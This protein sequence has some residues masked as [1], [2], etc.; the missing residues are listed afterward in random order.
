MK[1]REECVVCIVKGLCRSKKTNLLF[2]ADCRPLVH[3]FSCRCLQMWSA[4][5]RP[6]GSEKTNTTL[7]IQKLSNGPLLSVGPKVFSKIGFYLF[8]LV[9]QT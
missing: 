5:C 1:E 6:F 2:L 9:S 4:D 8:F 7:I 3:L